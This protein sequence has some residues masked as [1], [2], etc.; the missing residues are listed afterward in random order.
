MDEET[1]DLARRV[2]KLELEMKLL[3]NMVRELESKYIL[4]LSL[5]ASLQETVNTMSRVVSKLCT[6]HMAP[7]TKPK[8]IVDKTP[9]TDMYQ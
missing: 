7:P 1:E 2:R 4:L 3:L 6:Y 9:S 5:V 8:P